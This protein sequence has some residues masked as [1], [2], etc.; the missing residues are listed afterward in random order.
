MSDPTD[1]ALAAIASILD[2]TTTPPEKS[3]PSDNKSSD[4]KPSDETADKASEPVEEPPVSIAMPPPLPSSVEVVTVEAVSIDT[5]SMDAA[6]AEPTTV[7]P[8]PIEEAELLV[9]QPEPNEPEPSVPEPEPIQP[10]QPIE[11]NG[12]SKSGPGPMAALRFRWTVR[13]DGAQY[14]VDETV[15]EGSTPLVNGPM[16][17]DAAIKFVDDREAE[18]RRRFEHFKHEIVS[19]TAAALQASR[20]RHEA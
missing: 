15:G 16:D 18:A 19:R 10:P 9:E 2:Q 1:N 4:T 7:E 13:E 8:P 14:Y 11:A 6:P 20:D 12:Y 3:K 17:R 5:E